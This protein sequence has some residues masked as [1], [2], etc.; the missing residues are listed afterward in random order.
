MTEVKIIFAND[1]LING[2][3]AR[4]NFVAQQKAGHC[5]VLIEETHYVV[6]KEVENANIGKSPF[7][8]R[9]HCA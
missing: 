5:S 2:N 8:S 7:N 1:E 4:K 9:E 3:E 6:I